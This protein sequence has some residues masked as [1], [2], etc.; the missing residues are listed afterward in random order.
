MK[1]GE[2]ACNRL[3]R[4]TVI[5]HSNPAPVIS[6]SQSPRHTYLEKREETVI[7][8][9]GR[10]ARG[11]C[12]GFRHK[13]HHSMRLI[14]LSDIQELAYR[15]GSAASLCSVQCSGR[16]WEHHEAHRRLSAN[17]GR[18]AIC[19]HAWE[20]SGWPKVARGGSPGKTA[21]GGYL[22]VTLELAEIQTLESRDMG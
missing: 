1:P 13:P 6:G 16:P 15:E 11:A 14:S 8:L 2:T 3:R 21:I 4:N 10:Q 7:S 18:A 12:E 17:A 5:L 20:N 19:Q 22:S 9:S